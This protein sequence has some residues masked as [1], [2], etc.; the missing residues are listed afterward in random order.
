MFPRLVHPFHLAA[1]ALLLALLPASLRAAYVKE[2]QLV[3]M[4]DGIRLATDIY[5]PEGRRPWPVLLVRTVYSRNAA[6][7]PR[8]AESR[9][10]EGWVLVIQDTRGRFDSEGANHA[11]EADGWA[12]HHDGADTL[13]WI[14][15][16]PWCNGQVATGG[17]SA[18]GITQLLLAGKGAQPIA[19]QH[20]VVGAPNLY[21]I[22]YRQGV[23]RRSMIEDWLKGT[24]FAPEMLSLWTKH[25]SYDA[26]WEKRNLEGRYDSI[27]TPAL[28]YGGWF[29]IFTQGTIDSYIGYND[30]GGRG[31]R[32]KQRLLMGPWTHA[33]GSAQAGDLS[34]PDANKA[35]TKARHLGD[36]INFKVKGV[37]RGIAS[38]P[39]VIYYVMG[40]TSDPRAPGNFWRGANRWPRPDARPTPFYLHADRALTTAKPLE[41]GSLSYVHDPADP[42]PTV[43][44]PWL[45]LPAGPK[46]Q[47]IVEARP[48]VLVFT[49]EPLTAPLEVTGRLSAKL[50]ISSD[51]PDTDFFVRLCIVGADGRS[52][53]IAEGAIRARFW[54][55]LREE[56][57]LQPGEVYPLMIDLWSTSI[58]FNAGNRLRVQVASSSAPGYEVNP[59]D[60]LPLKASGP[61]RPARNTLHLSPE[62]PSQIILP[63]APYR[64]DPYTGSNP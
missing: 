61:P 35:P 51:A 56:N 12:G 7:V 55:S 60:G 40:D 11:F 4:S 30:H 19:T 62:H 34:F 46:D 39:P 49:S 54:K 10:K 41:A 53:N 8:D 17:A 9:T 42:V 1:A 2:T 32:G 36:W 6:H 44:G 52:Y 59:N 27:G 45:T 5:R 57:L 31:A 64:F 15:R 23:F 58:V 43:G 48:D 3:E 24:G 21:D 50:W 63:V 37:D 14:R 26:Y 47:A 22:V 20:I 13:A 28:H 29:D 25:S 38:D 33:V 16:Q 18:L